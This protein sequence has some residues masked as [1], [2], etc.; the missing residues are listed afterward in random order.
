MQPRINYLAEPPEALKKMYEL[1]RLIRDSGLD[2]KLIHLVKTGASQLNGCAF[3]IDMHTKDSRAA[4]ERTAAVWING[5]ARDTVLHGPG[6]G[7]AW[8]EALTNI[9]DGHRMRF[10]GL[11]ASTLSSAISRT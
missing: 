4:G 8:T 9:Q 11:S 3:C 7:R 6:A 5:L 1:E 2:A 10:I